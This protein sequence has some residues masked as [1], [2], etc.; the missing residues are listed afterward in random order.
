MPA[1]IA[2]TPLPG[3]PGSSSLPR[4]L[5]WRHRDNARRQVD[6]NHAKMAARWSHTPR[7]S[8]VAGR[9]TRWNAWYPNSSP[10]GFGAERGSNE[11]MPTKN[12]I[13]DVQA[14]R[15]ASLTEPT[16]ILRMPLCRRVRSTIT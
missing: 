3:G 10:I 4:A 6:S 9:R 5:Q 8:R 7:L 14:C 15:S 1:Q 16:G 11:S 13:D 2:I 12:N